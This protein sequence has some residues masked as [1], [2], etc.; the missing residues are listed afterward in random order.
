[1]T[2]GVKMV[3]CSSAASRAKLLGM[4]TAW[5]RCVIFGLIITTMFSFPGVNGVEDFCVMDTLQ[6]NSTWLQF[7]KEL[8]S[9]EY[10]VT[11]KFKSLHC[12]AK[13]YRSI[14]WYKD[15]RPYPWPGEVSGFI[16]YPESANQT[17]YSKS[18]VESDSGNYTCL[19]RNDTDE[20]WHTINVTVM[21]AAGYSGIP[22]Q[23][24][25][26]HDLY[27]QTG[28]EA[29]F[30]CEAFVGRIDLPD[31]HNKVSWKR[32]EHNSSVTLPERF[33]VTSKPREDNEIL[34]SYM[35][36][37][38]VRREDFGQYTCQI[39]N[40]WFQS[41][42]TSVWLR[43]IVPYQDESQDKRAYKQILLVFAVVI[44]S[45]LTLVALYL[46]F[47][48]QMQV[49]WKDSFCK[50]ETSDGKEYDVLICYDDKDSDFVLGMLVPTLETRYD[51]RC[52]THH[53]GSTDEN[54]GTTWPAVL[55]GTAQRS[56]RLLVVL[57]P[58]LLH[59]SWT[60]T[61]LYQALHT[62]L[63]VHSRIICVTL[64]PL[65]KCESAKNAQGDSLP[66]LLRAVHLVEWRSEGYCFGMG[67]RSRAHKRFWASIRLHL[68]PHR[69]SR[70]AVSPKQELNQMSMATTGS[71]G[72]VCTAIGTSKRGTLLTNS[73]ESLEVL[74]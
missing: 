37:H 54:S 18:V 29:R 42:D 14:E 64:Q 26:P 61:A 49:I 58:S 8:S 56:R 55:N 33:Q 62:L 25:E 12:C 60:S 50:Q 74:V 24:Y 71:G 39:S 47:G 45:S 73:H 43:E 15:G 21:D 17:I 67:D 20:L 38:G 27:V 69:H 44:L 28:D 36:I 66:A 5:L 1:M 4:K 11:Q 35:L 65:P 34:G 72:N 3:S 16:L 31:A 13:G 2:T 41:V 7:T 51:Y 53:L 32:V 68:P 23:M 40:T 57:S 9:R 30:F 70:Q 48:L 46:R 22:L 10:V 63:T 6:N 59:D 52:F 19:V